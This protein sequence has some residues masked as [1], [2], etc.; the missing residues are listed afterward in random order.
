MSLYFNKKQ[1]NIKTQNICYQSNW[2]ELVGIEGKQ[3]LRKEEERR[4]IKKNKERE[5]GG[6]H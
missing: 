6:F 5:G 1:P 4:K 2:Q 3:S